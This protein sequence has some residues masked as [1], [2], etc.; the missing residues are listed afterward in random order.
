MKKFFAVVFA[1]VLMIMSFTLSSSASS[2]KA[3]PLSAGVEALR[4]QFEPAVAE[5]EDGC[6]IDYYF[7]SPVKNGD[8]KKYPV[9]IF[10]HG[11][12]HGA[13]VGSQR[14]DSEM[15]Y[16]ASQELQSRWT[17]A[18]GAFIIL[19]R[20]PENNVEYWNASFINPLRRMI[21]CFI[22]EHKDNVDTT[23]IFIGGSS[24]GGEMAWDMI[25]TY[26][27]YFAGAFPLSATGIY[28]ADDITAAKDVAIWIFAS[29]LDPLVNYPL[30]VKP[31]WN[32]VCKYNANPQ[33]CRLS[34]F[35]MVCNPD[36]E[37]AW[38]NHRL[39]Q[40]ISYD[41][42]T[43]DNKPYPNVETEDGLGNKV[44]FESPEG[45]ISWMSGLHSD[46]N[47]EA[48]SSIKKVS[49]FDSL[50]IPFRNIIFKIG[51]LIQKLLGLV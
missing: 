37:I 38:E 1:A 11:I 51:N 22:K 47:G 30:D 15:A 24:A 46:F 12:G 20:C 45:M 8:N 3:L 23:R 36:G 6:A 17:D 4:A 32:R 13:Y 9:V 16:W 18:G 19:P 49:F 31:L 27:E 25:T 7:Y 21:D 48:P 50:M 41:F 5:E 39:F 35:T 14:D 2:E 10:L 44:N 33:N 26:P 40:T 42:F 43:I 28:N 34:S 29:K